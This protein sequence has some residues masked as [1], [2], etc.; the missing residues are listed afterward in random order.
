M[1]HNAVKPF[2]V[3][4]VAKD[5]ALRHECL[6]IRDRLGDRCGRGATR[7]ASWRPRLHVGS[8]QRV[9]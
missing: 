7:A 6:N 8:H 5:S 9:G 1:M 4:V 3:T 2:C